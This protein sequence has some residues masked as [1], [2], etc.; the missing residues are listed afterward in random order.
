LFQNW[1]LARIINI[2]RKEGKKE[3]RKKKERKLLRFL[4]NKL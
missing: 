2:E 1:Q 4:E 3:E